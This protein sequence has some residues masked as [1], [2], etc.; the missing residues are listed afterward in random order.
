MAID[1]SQ[2]AKGERDARND[3]YLQQ[4][5]ELKNIQDSYAMQALGM[6]MQEE[7]AA[8]AEKQA[9]RQ[10]ATYLTPFNTYLANATKLG[11]NDVD[12]FKTQYDV[13]QN[14]EN[15]KNFSPE[16][17]SKILEQYNSFGLRI[18]K[19]YM[20][21]GQ[22][23]VA[24]DIL[25][26]IGQGSKTVP[27]GVLA[28]QSGDIARIAAS[29]GFTY[30]ATKQTVTKDGISLPASVLLQPALQTKGIGQSAGIQALIDAQN[31]ARLDS[32]AVTAQTA[33]DARTLDQFNT[34]QAAQNRASYIS[35]A[36]SAGVK[37][38]PATGVL[39]LPNGLKLNSNLEIVAPTPTPTPAPAQSPSPAPAPASPVQQAAAQAA[40]AITPEIVNLTN[41]AVA[42]GQFNGELL[43]FYAN[44]P[45]SEIAVFA[46]AYPYLTDGIRKA[47]GEQYLAYQNQQKDETNPSRKLVLQ[48]QMD[49][50]IAQANLY[51]GNR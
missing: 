15:F 19:D 46:K 28:L 11:T 21:K 34:A 26:Y 3:A 45:A 12:F 35:L 38:D 30:D 47:L 23:N 37:V 9:A 31:Q 4:Q 42:T 5:R 14:D 20:D 25:T 17:Q 18:A 33:S 44:L 49:K 48:T 40:Q 16:V 32:A 51:K 8:F 50:L 27:E 43:Q 29:Q 10:A 39:T 36:S 24:N 1:F 7:Q 6:K 13:I 41:Q 22:S 2:I